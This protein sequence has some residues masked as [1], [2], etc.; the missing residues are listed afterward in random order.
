MH[1]LMSCRWGFNDVKHYTAKS[2]TTWECTDLQHD[3]KQKKID[4][5]ISIALPCVFA[6]C[7]SI[8]NDRQHSSSRHYLRALIAGACPMPELA[9]CDSQQCGSLAGLILFYGLFWLRRSGHTTS[10][11]VTWLRRVRNSRVICCHITSHDRYTHE[12]HRK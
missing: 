2:A 10:Y 7:I 3:I 5:F 12:K 11:D 6:D 9:R 4:G 1:S 8:R